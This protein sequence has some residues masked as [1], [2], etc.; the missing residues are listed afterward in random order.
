M[1]PALFLAHGS[2]MLAIEDTVYSGF[3]NTLSR[4]VQPKAIVI[5]TAHWESEVLTISSLDGTYDTIYDFGGFPD[6]L[7]QIKYP[8]KG[9]TTIASKVEERF[10]QQ[11]IPVKKD[12][13]RGLDHG[14]WTLLYRMYPKADI[15]VVQISVHPYLPPDKQFRIGECLRELGEEDILV[16]GSGVTVHNLRMIHWG[17]SAPEPWAIAFDDWLIDKVEKRDLESLFNYEK[18]APYA[19]QAV[20][21]PEHFVPFFIAMGSGN[22]QNTPKVIHRSYDHGTLSYLSYQ[23]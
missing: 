11:G 13:S 6:A 17:Q 9:S 2:P 23:F 22:P 21:R 16:I 20:P 3:L 18:L 19:R 10:Q 14:S 15:P 5:F 8:A 4:Q 12:T 7:Y 1:V